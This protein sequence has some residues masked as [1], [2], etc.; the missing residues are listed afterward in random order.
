MTRREL[1]LAT[2]TVALVI[3]ML[4]LL[5]GS[6]LWTRPLWFDE[7]CCVTYVVG[8]APSPVEVVRRVARS[9]DY[10]PPLLHLLVWPLAR[11]GGGDLTPVMLRSFSVVSVALGLLFVYATLRRRF[12]VLPGV[13]GIIA[14]AGHS[15]V[16]AH[17]FEGRFYGPWFLLAAAYA[18][19]LGVEAQRR[20]DLAQAVFAVFLVSMHWFAVFSLTLMIGGALLALPGS[21]RVRLRYVAWSA[22]GFLAAIALAPMAI[23]QRSGAVGYLWLPALDIGQVSEM[24]KLFWLG[25]VP[26][27]AALLLLARTLRRPALRESIRAPLRD[28]ALAAMLALALMPVVL[29]VISALVQP[30][31]LD[32]YAIVTV[33]AWAPLV[34]FAMSAMGAAA[35]VGAVIALVLVMVLNGQRALKARQDFADGVTAAAG[36]F[37]E[38]KSKGLP[39][40][41]WGLHS[42]YPVAGRLS[43]RS[44]NA[45]ARYLD[46]PDSSLLALFPGDA[47][48]PV[49][50]K[51]RLDRDQAR[52]HARTYGF[53]VLA[54]QAQLD[55]TDRFILLA[56][57]FSLPGGYKRPESFGRALFPAHR[58]SRVNGML[59]LFER[60]AR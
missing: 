16:L 51:Y 56:G 3:A 53:P 11:A 6:I 46:L 23:A 24:A 52:G 50:K 40:V 22:L 59:S 13:G 28:P 1:V 43:E 34:A 37:K 33:I 12:P 21:L 30:S 60:E 35:R 4:P 49:R 57:D 47:M 31:M 36:A 58:V 48:E 42:I 7:L 55:S 5:G 54:T 9:W 10:A 20:R 25:V 18:W 17:A 26:V 15:V 39:I 32:R 19:S 41:F 8:D 38:A 44:N 45:L 27:V 2:T 29:I 14:I